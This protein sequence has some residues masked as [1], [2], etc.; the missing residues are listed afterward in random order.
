MSATNNRRTVWTV[1]WFLAVFAASALL[2]RMAAGY[3]RPDREIDHI[4]KAID[5]LDRAHDELVNA[6]DDFHGHKKAA[7]EKT[8]R[9]RKVLED[10]RDARVDKAADKIQDAIDELKACVA[11]EPEER[12][13]RIH[14]ALH[15]LEDAK[16]QL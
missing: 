1:S 6:A 14:R 4:V 5:A 15:A 7:M 8:E 11:D 13:P 12:H 3:G 9:A 10:S 16:G 2:S